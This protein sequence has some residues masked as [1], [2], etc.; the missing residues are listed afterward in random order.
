MNNL[1][2]KQE[3]IKNAYVEYWEK[4]KDYV[5]NHGF[6]NLDNSFTYEDMGLELQD[7]GNWRPPSLSG[8]EY[9]NGWIELKERFDFPKEKGHY[10]FF[11]KNKKICQNYFNPN[12][13][14]D[15]YR[16]HFL[17]MYN[18]FALHFLSD[19]YY[20][21]AEDYESLLKYFEVKD[22]SEK[23]NKELKQKE[24]TTK[25]KVSKI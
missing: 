24:E 19:E 6:A 8:I 23:L 1:E 13:R 2:A 21:N 10:W 3:A 15:G 25:K 11:T 5:D 20:E 7:N 16:Q 9:N 14:E 18:S 12:S 17:N 22:L 4:V